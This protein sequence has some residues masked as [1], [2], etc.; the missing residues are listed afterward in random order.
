MENLNFE[1]LRTQFAIL[2]EQLSKQEI[3]SDRLLRNAMK[4]KKN[5][6]NYTKK[7]AFAGA[8]VALLVY[9]L[10][11]FAQMWSWAFSI[12]TSLMMIFCIVAT[13]YIHRPVEAL[14]FM[15]DDFAT[16][17]R[18]MAKFKKQY[19][20]WIHYVVPAFIIPWICW[21]CYEMAWKH[22][23]E[24]SN[25]WMRTIPVIIGLILGGA[26]G[27]KYHRKAVNAAQDIINQI[28]EN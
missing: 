22:A 17:A 9:P 19:E 25:P 18:V 23:P 13:Y 27:L 28:E 16:V 4:E 6:I 7:L 15:K 14:N 2:K 12:A 3:V 21:A 10:S 5:A 8:A 11:S 1:D 24:G 20:D 26:I